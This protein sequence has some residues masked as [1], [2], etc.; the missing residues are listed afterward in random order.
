[1]FG[2]DDPITDLKSIVQTVDAAD[3]GSSPGYLNVERGDAGPQDYENGGIVADLENATV[4]DTHG[5]ARDAARKWCV[6]ADVGL[7]EKPLWAA[8]AT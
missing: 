5:E 4:F 8:G 2:D 1:M 3:F 7:I 6:Q